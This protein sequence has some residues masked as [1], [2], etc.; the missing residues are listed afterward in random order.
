[1][2][3]S[4]CSPPSF[5]CL[6]TG[7]LQWPSRFFTAQ[8]VPDSF[9]FPFGNPTPSLCP[10]AFFFP[11]THHFREIRSGTTLSPPCMPSLAI[12]G[13]VS[14]RMKISPMFLNIGHPSPYALCPTATL[15]SNTTEHGLCPLS[16]SNCFFSF[17]VTHP[18]L[19]TRHRRLPRFNLFLRIL[20]PFP[21][22]LGF[23]Y[24]CRSVDFHFPFLFRV[25]RKRPLLCQ[26]D[27]FL[28]PCESK[29]NPGTISEHRALLA[30]L[31]AVFLD[32]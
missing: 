1:L 7:Y 16:P 3:I 32:I 2:P 22:R 21:D 5:Y 19:C 12:D 28:T 27:V 8:F 25:V 4:R 6:A 9:S 11:L 31:C 10:S 23:R 13:P 24:P 14:P 29:V 20:F 17:F 18:R 26:L 15:C 30:L